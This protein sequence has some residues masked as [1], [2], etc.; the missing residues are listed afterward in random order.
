MKPLLILTVGLPRAGKSTWARERD[1]PIV[2]PDSIRLAIH[3]QAFYAPAE[4]IVWATAHIMV[5]ALF[6]AGH[7]TVV[8]DATNLTR[9]RRNEWL[10]SDW[11]CAFEVFPTPVV[12]CVRRA[13]ASDR[14]D[15]V[16]VIERMSKRIE[17][18]MEAVSGVKP[19]LL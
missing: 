19:I 18:P 12:E 10:S 5:A 9:T 13:I 17:W 11:D 8:L 2:N 3:G 1:Y 6:K 14:P 16:A 4:P 7:Q 15:L